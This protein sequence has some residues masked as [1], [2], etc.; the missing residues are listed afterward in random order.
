MVDL[1]FHLFLTRALIL[2]EEK[3]KGSQIAYM[4]RLPFAA[5]N[6]FSASMLDTL[7]YQSFVKN[8]MISFSRQLLGLDQAQ[9]SGYLCEVRK[10][11]FSRHPYLVFVLLE[12][13]TFRRA[14][15]LRHIFVGV[16]VVCF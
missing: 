16:N 9:D 13:Q 5:G 8:Y 3:E 1:R 14:A 15:S 2:Q 11:E 10:A 4:F 7:L 6:V 12:S